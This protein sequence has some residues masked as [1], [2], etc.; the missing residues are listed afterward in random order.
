[1]LKVVITTILLALGTMLIGCQT[2]GETPLQKKQ[3]FYRM[4]ELNRLMLNEDIESFWLL[5]R[6]SYLTR[7]RVPTQTIK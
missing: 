4:A 6:P 2:M 3:S 1:M 7:W 5:D